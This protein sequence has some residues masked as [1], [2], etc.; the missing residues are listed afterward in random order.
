MDI[1]GNRMPTPKQKMQAIQDYFNQPMPDLAETMQRLKAGMVDQ[2]PEAAKPGMFDTTEDVS[3]R[4]KAALDMAAQRGY[5]TQKPEP[6]EAMSDDDALQTSAE[7]GD[8]DAKT[9]LQ[10]LHPELYDTLKKQYGW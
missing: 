3:Q 5:L 2:P 9:K 4:H 8:E 7:F 10:R 1:K 6:K